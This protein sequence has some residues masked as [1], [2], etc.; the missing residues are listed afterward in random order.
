MTSRTFVP[1]FKVRQYR[2][3]L[4]DEW[5]TR[6]VGIAPVPKSLDE[7]ES[8]G[9][10]LEFVEI[11]CGGHS[12]NHGRRTKRSRIAFASRWIPA[13]G[14]AFRW[15]LRGSM[16]DMADTFRHNASNATRVRDQRAA[17]RPPRTRADDTRKRFRE[18]LDCSACGDRIIFADFDRFSAVWDELARTGRHIVT[19]PEVRRMY[20]SFCL[21]SMK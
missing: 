6:R 3:R 5:V 20:A 17:A 4:G 16:G 11:R 14:E 9:L 7:M 1:T 12:I 10:R 18:V 21:D 8:K 15:V 2:I 19:I 13:E